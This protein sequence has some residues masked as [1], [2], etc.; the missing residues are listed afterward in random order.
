[1]IIIIH[2]IATKHKVQS[3][4]SKE[5]NI[6]VSS[7]SNLSHSSIKTTL[8]TERNMADM[9]FATA[10]SAG[11]ITR[12]MSAKHILSICLHIFKKELNWV[13]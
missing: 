3:K 4:T 5:S 1:M 12:Y 7:N 2:N 10:D 9:K 13:C 11:N 6:Y 8:V